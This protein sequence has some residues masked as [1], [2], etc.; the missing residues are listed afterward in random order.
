M[1]KLILSAYTLITYS[2]I[3][4]NYNCTL[5]IGYSQ[6]GSSYGGW[7][8]AGSGLISDFEQMV[9]DANWQ[10]LWNSGGG[11]DKWKNPNYSG[12]LNSIESTC[13]INSNNPERALLSISGNY[14]V[15]VSAWVNDINSTISTIRL[16]YPSIQK[17][18][19]QAVV[20][21]PAH[22]TC[23]VAGDSIRAS[24]QHKYIDSAINIV[25]GMDSL[26]S[27]E[28][29]PEVNSCGDYKDMLGHLDTVIAHIIGAEIGQCYT[30]FTSNT[31]DKTKNDSFKIH[32]N[33]TNDLVTLEIEGCNGPFKVEIYN[34]QGRLL[35]TTKSRTVSLKKY[36]KGIYIFR[37]SYGDITEELRVLRD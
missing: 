3:A 26:V 24:W 13:S 1:K 34:L 28:C 21:G 25:I 29:S 31:I 35:E 17:I 22:Q 6:V 32:P 36:S 27:S 37:V 15:N 7:Y 10:L 5:V 30:T 11:I 33:P 2:L 23:Y 4:Q 20:G 19:L 18:L 16:K 8:V 14:G 12:W 9:G